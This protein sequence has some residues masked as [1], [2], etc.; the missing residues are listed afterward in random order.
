MSSIKNA[1]R[2][3]LPPSHPDPFS[4]RERVRVSLQIAHGK[5]DYQFKK[6]KQED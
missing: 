4:M 1:M 3:I 5:E 2:I 6:K